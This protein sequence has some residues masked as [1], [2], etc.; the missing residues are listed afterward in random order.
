[1]HVVLLA[2]FVR[3]LPIFWYEKLTECHLV[4]QH[5]VRLD[6]NGDKGIY[7][8]RDDTDHEKLKRGTS[9]PIERMQSVIWRSFIT[10]TFIEEVVDDY[11]KLYT[12]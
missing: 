6:E 4:S 10:T 3:P 2:N 12:N 7:I 5:E 11:I 9:A 1:M 8:L